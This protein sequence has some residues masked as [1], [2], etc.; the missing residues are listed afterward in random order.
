MPLS[1]PAKSSCTCP[2]PGVCR[3]ILAA[4]LYLQGTAGAAIEA[5]QNATP[6]SIR[7]EAVSVTSERLK[8][9]AGTAEYRAGVSLLEKNSLPPVIEY[10]ETVAIR[11]MPSCVEARFVPGGGL[12]GIV[13]PRALGKRVAVAAVLVLRRSAG[14]E[15]AESGV[16]QAL[17][18]VSGAPRTPKEILASAQSVLEGAVT[19]GLSHLSPAVVERLLTLAVS[20][21]AA[22]LPRVSLALRS[23]SDEVGRY[24]SAKPARMSLDFFS[25]QPRFTR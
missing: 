10:G 23:V 20:A 5:R 7:E 19:V 21:Q 9:W 17:I 8:E 3:H 15:T 16:Q 18:E 14:L 22:N 11:L 25:P 4:G 2:A 1:G 24:F 6:A 12:D 13:G